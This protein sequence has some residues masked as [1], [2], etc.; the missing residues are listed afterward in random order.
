M[1][2]VC[3]VPLYSQH[4][5]LE[6]RSR[7]D[8]V[9]WDQSPYSGLNYGAAVQYR[10]EF[11]VELCTV[12]QDTPSG[13]SCAL[14]CRYVLMKFLSMWIYVL[15]NLFLSHFLLGEPHIHSEYNLGVILN[16]ASTH[17]LH[18]IHVIMSTPSPSPERHLCTRY[19]H[20]AVCAGH[21]RFCQEWW[22][23]AASNFMGI[24]SPVGCLLLCPI[25]MLE[26]PALRH[27]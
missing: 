1:F 12:H 3:S 19:I 11:S 4:H 13:D 2:L 15:S 26:R 5:G 10:G 9:G 17:C 16:L 23:S 14:F 18:Y 22:G 6:Q 25:K 27:L 7:T 24:H 20:W 21:K 8:G